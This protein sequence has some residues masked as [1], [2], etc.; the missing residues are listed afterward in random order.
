M[1]RGRVA[2][3]LQSV[4]KKLPEQDDRYKVSFTAN[5]QREVLKELQLTPELKG[6]SEAYNQAFDNFENKLKE[7]GK[8]S[9][10]IGEGDYRDPHATNNL[11]QMVK[12]FSERNKPKDDK[13]VRKFYHATKE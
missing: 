10:L 13:K 3:S 6:A 4:G 1:L 12:L 8:I 7:L 2:E 11:S 5:E 9:E